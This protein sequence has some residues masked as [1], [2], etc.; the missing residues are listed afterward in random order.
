[1]ATGDIQVVVTQVIAEEGTD[2][3][4]NDVILASTFPATNTDVTIQVIP[5][6][7]DGKFVTYDVIAQGRLV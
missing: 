4:A 6:K 5:R 3:D 1:M 2:F 7:T